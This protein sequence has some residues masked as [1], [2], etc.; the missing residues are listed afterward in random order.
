MNQD[1]TSTEEVVTVT[2]ADGMRIIWDMPIRMDDGVVLRA[3][4]FLPQTPGRYATILSYGPYA[5]GLS[6]QTSYKSAWDSMI[7][8]CPEIAEGT[9]NKYQNWEVVDPEK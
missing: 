8:S 5:K 3:D 2:E 4:I 1:P 7:A 6:F 9:S